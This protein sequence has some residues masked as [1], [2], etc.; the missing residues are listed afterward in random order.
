[1]VIR[2]VRWTHWTALRAWL[3]LVMTSEQHQPDPLM[4]PP[5][6]STQELRGKP[7]G[8]GLSAGK[9]FQEVSRLC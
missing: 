6:T 1:M 2:E 9:T 7:I 4:T 3:R 5:A 8:K